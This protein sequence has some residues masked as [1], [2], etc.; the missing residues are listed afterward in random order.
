M[1]LNVEYFHFSDLTTK[2]IFDSKAASLNTQHR[3]PNH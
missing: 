3:N 1:K 2:T